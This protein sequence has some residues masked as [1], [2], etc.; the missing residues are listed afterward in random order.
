[1]NS[2]ED[3]HGHIRNDVLLILSVENQAEIEETREVFLRKKFANHRNFFMR[4]PH[5]TY[6]IYEERGEAEKV[7]QELN[8]KHLPRSVVVTGVTID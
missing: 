4:T 5:V 1:V 7:A 6:G 8:A 2:F 3:R